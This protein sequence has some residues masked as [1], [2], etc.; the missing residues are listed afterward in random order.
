MKPKVKALLINLGLSVFV[1]FLCVFLAEAGLR[2]AGYGNIELYEPHSTLYWRLKPN[3]ERYTKIGRKPVVTN[4][5]GTR[6]PEFAVPKPANHLRILTLG[7]SRTFGWGLSAEETFSGRLEKLLQDK[8]GSAKKVEVINA[9]VN[10]WS[11]PQ[12][13][14]F[15][16]T[17]G[18]SYEPDIVVV[19]DANL[20]TQFSDKNSPEFVAAF[21]R[22][23]WLKNFLRRFALYH[24]IIEVKLESFYQ[25]HRTKFI[26]VDPKR[27]ELFK[28]QQQS[29][30]AAVYR[31]SLE[32]I[33]EAAVKKGVT[34]IFL[35]LP[36]LNDLPPAP[37][38]LPG[39]AKLAMQKE[40]NAAVV[41]VTEA[42]APKGEKLYLEADPVHFNVEGNEIIAEKLYQTISKE[43]KL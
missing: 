11:Y 16:E 37:P 3:Q 9:G 8:L 20:W 38:H 17:E 28:E 36:T 18:V 40:K 23:V 29:D 26:P 5:R 10:A 15:F 43:L 34:P 13:A 14:M 2:I 30:P 42:I 35:V 12:M 33:H 4:S 32:R 25:K 21:K 1:F 31:A 39:Q 24:Y 7:D 19:G 41:D 27:D 22:R 6:G